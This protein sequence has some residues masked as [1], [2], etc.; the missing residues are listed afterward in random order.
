MVLLLPSEKI[1]YCELATTLQFCTVT[2]LVRISIRATVAAL[3]SYTP[4]VLIAWMPS[5]G[6]GRSSAPGGVATPP[7]P[8]VWAPGGSSGLVVVGG[9]VLVVEVDG[10]LGLAV[11]V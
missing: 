2:L 5:S 8:S 1:P 10:G 11:T 3:Q 6:A 9:G 4:A 7:T